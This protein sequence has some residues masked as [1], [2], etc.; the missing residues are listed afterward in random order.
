MIITDVPGHFVDGSTMVTCFLNPDDTIQGLEGFVRMSE[1]SVNKLVGPLTWL[2]KG[3]R[4]L[5]V[6]EGGR[7][8]GGR[9]LLGISALQPD[10]RLASV[11]TF[12]RAPGTDSGPESPFAGEN[13]RRHDTELV[14]THRIV[15]GGPNKEDV[16]F[17]PVLGSIDASGNWSGEEF[18][19]KGNYFYTVCVRLIGTDRFFICDPEME[20][21]P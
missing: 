12:H 13:P 10:L 1:Y 2:K 21:G 19:N 7:S 4:T 16:C 14:C 11:V 15:G 6:D 9:C 8:D 18:K 5:T 17:Y 3:K 20:I